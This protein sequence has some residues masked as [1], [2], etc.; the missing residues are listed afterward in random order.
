MRAPPM[1]DPTAAPAIAPEL[2]CGPDV[3]FEEVLVAGLGNVDVGGPGCE[4]VGICEGPGELCNGPDVGLLEA[5]EAVVLGG[6]WIPGIVVSLPTWKVV[7]PV[8]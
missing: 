4:D 1:R 8:I 7:V 3:C 2:N 6:S 5:M